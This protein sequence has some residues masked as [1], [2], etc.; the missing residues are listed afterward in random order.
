M[1]I[2]FIFDCQ[3]D[4]VLPKVPDESAYYSRQFYV[5][6]IT[7]CQGTSK[8]KQVKENT[9]MYIWLETEY[10]NGSN[11]I[12]SF[13]YHRLKNTDLTNIHTMRLFS[14]GCGGQNK[15][16]VMLSMLSKFLLECP[17]HINY[18]YPIVGH[19]FILSDRIFGRLKKKFRKIACMT[20]IALM[21][22]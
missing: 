2:T 8:S 13:V 17:N 15:N 16:K 20:I 19:S 22:T 1:K 4:L 6:N 5:H 12:A 14:D 21:I 7:V 18:F 11:K 10:N 3:K 9:F